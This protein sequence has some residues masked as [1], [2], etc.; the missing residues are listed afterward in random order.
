MKNNKQEI[1]IIENTLI[2]FISSKYAPIFH[3]T[4]II[5]Q[6]IPNNINLLRL[7]SFN[8]LLTKAKGSNAIHHTKYYAVHTLL[9]ATNTIVWINMQNG[10]SLKYPK[11][12]TIIKINYGKKA[13]MDYIGVIESKYR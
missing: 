7:K 9:K 4:S 13:N 6:N 5:N 8:W 1:K 12:A 10:K 2:P 3:Y 11:P